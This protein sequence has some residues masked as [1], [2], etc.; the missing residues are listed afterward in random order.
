MMG[1]GAAP[2]PP[3]IVQPPVLP[4]M[5][6]AAVQAASARQAAIMQAQTGRASTI[7]GTPGQG[8]SKL[9]Q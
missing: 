8:Q 3:T 7:M 2:P 4:T 9:G 1:G 6:T 5:N